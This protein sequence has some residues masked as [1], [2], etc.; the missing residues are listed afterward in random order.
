MRVDLH[1]KVR[2]RDGHEA[3]HVHGAVVEPHANEVRDIIVSTGGWLGHDVLVPRDEIDRASDDGDA[4]RLQLTKAELEQLPVY[5]PDNY[6]LPPDGWTVPALPATYAFPDGGFLWPMGFVPTGTPVGVAA[7]GAAASTSPA[8]APATPGAPGITSTTGAGGTTDGASAPGAPADQGRPNEANVDRGSLVLDAAGKDVGVVD[9]V[10]FDEVTGQLRGFVVRF[11]GP[12]RTFFGG[13]E[14]AE[15]G[16]GEVERV[17]DGIV[18]L[19]R[20]AERGN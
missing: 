8:T 14:T 3:G 19:R 13:G 18:Q 1:A 15:L 4:L 6:G 17:S 20:A 5:L 11:G 2:T 9:D 16:M 10:R 12:F 7:A